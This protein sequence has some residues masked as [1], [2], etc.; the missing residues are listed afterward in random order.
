[1]SDATKRTGLEEL[2]LSVPLITTEK[3]TVELD[4]FTLDEELAFAVLDA[5]EEITLEATLE[6]EGT[7]LGDEP[8]LDV[9]KIAEEPALELERATL[10]DE[11]AETV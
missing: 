11:P 5:A 3:A 6:L 9:L 2:A 10:E 1:M 8:V 4:S 7:T